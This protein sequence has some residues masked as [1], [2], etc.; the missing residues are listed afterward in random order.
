MGQLRRK[1]IEE[2]KP[3]V[4]SPKPV[5]SAEDREVTRQSLIRMRG[6]M[7]VEL[8]AKIEALMTR[9]GKARS[10]QEKNT[11]K[12]QVAQLSNQLTYLHQNPPKGK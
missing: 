7:M 6:Q 4:D 8:Q 11:L 2:K 5:R 3:L 9:L 10:V 1:A 12:S